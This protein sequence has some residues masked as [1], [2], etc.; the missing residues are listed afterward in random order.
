MRLL[1]E[2][3]LAQLQAQ[4]EKMVGELASEELEEDLDSQ[5]T[6]GDDGKP[7]LRL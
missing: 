6:V 7:L 1:A 4:V 5:G 2:E 3:R